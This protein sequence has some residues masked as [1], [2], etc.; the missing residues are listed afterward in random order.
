MRLIRRHPGRNGA[1]MSYCIAGKDRLRS[2]EAQR[3]TVGNEGLSPFAGLLRDMTDAQLAAEIERPHRL[4]LDSEMVGNKR[5]DVAYWPSGPLNLDARVVIVGITAGRQQMRNAWREMRRCLQ[6]GMSEADA[7]AAARTIGSFSRPMRKNLVAMLDDI[8]VNHLLRVHSTASLW[9]DDVRLVQFTSVLR[10][11][12][13][14]DGENYRGAPPIFSTRILREHVMA[15]FG[16]DA[17]KIHH[18][19]FVPLGRVASKAVELVAKDASLDRNRVLAGMPHP[20]GANAERISFFLGRKPREELSR[21]VRPEPL[22][23][24]RAEL[25]AKIAKLISQRDDESEE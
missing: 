2:R 21:K 22:I 9:G 8:G 23:A 18:A 25:K 17:P 6:T 5:I 19:I 16:A 1:M 11:P 14:V 7:A 24:A 10:W 12:V 15:G 3:S 13:F 4:L 20:S